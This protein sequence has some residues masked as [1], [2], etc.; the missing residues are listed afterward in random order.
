ME[1][2]TATSE[3]MSDEDSRGS[4][5]SSLLSHSDDNSH[6]M[7]TPITNY[8]D[9][10]GSPPLAALH[11]M[12]EM[13]TSPG[14]NPHGIEQILSRPPPGLPRSFSSVANMAAAAGMAAASYFH[15]NGTK[16]PG[17]ADFTS[18]SSIYWPGL[19]GL[20]SNPIAWRDRLANCKYIPL[21][22]TRY[23][24]TLRTHLILCIQS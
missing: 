3:H 2:T 1:F 24:F 11:S 7:I 12:T 9:S 13:K 4:T 10:S 18:R 23:L 6:R 20:V 21:Y 8:L 17:L 15:H 16:H 14:G 22:Y 19:Q 5:Q